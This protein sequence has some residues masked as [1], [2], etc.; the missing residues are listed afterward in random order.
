ML[1]DEELEDKVYIEDWS[2]KESIL[3]GTVFGEF[4]VSSVRLFLWI[5]AGG[6]CSSL[7]WVGV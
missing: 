4:S 5:G 1:S 3:A 6:G 2:V 7:A